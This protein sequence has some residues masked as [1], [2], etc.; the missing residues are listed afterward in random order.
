[1]AS[2]QPLI[3]TNRLAMRPHQLS[4]APFMVE[5]NADPEVVRYTG[6]GPFAST[7]EAEAVV[8]ALM[9]QF[10][11]RK[12]GRFLLLERATGTPLGWCGLKWIEDERRVD[13]GYRLARAH[14]GKGYAT[15]A[16]AACVRYGFVELGLTTLTAE[17]AKDNVA[18]V[19]VL[20]KLGFTTVGEDHAC[21]GL[22]TWRFR[23][24]RG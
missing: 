11:E 2:T 1:M 19:R 10:A 20:H 16:G 9:R 14:W 15:E 24:E 6:D 3:E 22:P 23:L 12:M 13:L 5:L 17:A 7:A 4:D 18:S 8:R 21:A